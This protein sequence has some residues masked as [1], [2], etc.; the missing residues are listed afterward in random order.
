MCV[1][2]L[3]YCGEAVVPLVA[4]LVGQGQLGHALDLGVQV[5][6]RVED[7]VLVVQLMI[8]SCVC[9]SV[10]MCVQNPSSSSP[11]PSAHLVHG[12]V[13]HEPVRQARPAKQKDTH[14]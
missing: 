9:V 7:V 13:V 12:G 1:C 5:L 4:R 8:V 3:T 2:V 14:T 11:H 6:V 10:C